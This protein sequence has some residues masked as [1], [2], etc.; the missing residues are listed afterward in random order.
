MMVYNMA[1][2]CTKMENGNDGKGKVTV[3]STLNTLSTLPLRQYLRYPSCSSAE[4]P[5]ENEGKYL[6]LY[7]I[8]Y[9]RTVV[10]SW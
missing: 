7:N 1:F 9:S 5:T 6:L 2:K 4:L 3:N 8:T 10:Q